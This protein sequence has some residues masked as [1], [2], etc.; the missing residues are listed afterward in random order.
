MDTLT[1]ALAVLATIR[2]TRLLI[3]DSLP[4]LPALRRRLAEREISGGG[5]EAPPEPSALWTL[6][7]CPWCLSFW[8]GI[9]VLGSAM[10]W[11]STSAWR[12]IAGSLAL[13]LLT[14]TYEALMALAEDN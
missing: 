5:D 2:I 13:S 7:T 9:A 6:S 10:L 3:F 4:P 8:V 14:G 12:L 11:G 1:L